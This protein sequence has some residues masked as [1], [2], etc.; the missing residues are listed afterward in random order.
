MKNKNKLWLAVLLTVL[1]VSLLAAGFTAAAEGRSEISHILVHRSSSYG[2]CTWLDMHS[3]L[4]E[5]GLYEDANLRQYE[6]ETANSNIE[7]H[8][9]IQDGEIV[10][11]WY[12]YEYGSDLQEEGLPSEIQDHIEDYLVTEPSG[13]H[14]YCP[15]LTKEQASTCCTPGY[16]QK[17][18]AV[19]EAIER[20]EKPLDPNNHP[21]CVT[22]E[23]ELPTATKPGHEAGVQ[24]L[25]CGQ[26]LSGG[27]VIAPLAEDWGYCG[28]EGDGTNLVWCIDKNGT[29]TISGEGNMG[30]YSHGTSGDE[31]NPNN[32]LRYFSTAPWCG[33]AENGDRIKAVVIGSGVTGIG[34]NAFCYCEHLT[35]VTIA[36]SVTRVGAGAFYGCTAYAD[37]T[38]PDGITQ[39]GSGVYFGTAWYNA[40]PDGMVYVGKAAYKYKGNMPA[41][42]SV[43]IADGTKVIADEAFLYFSNL[44]RVTFPDSLTHI[45]YMAFC[46]CN[47][48][49]EAAFPEGLTDIA[50]FAF[51]RC[52][53]LKSV[54]IPEGVMHVGWSAFGWCIDMTDVSIP[55][56]L[57]VLE[58][59]VFCRCG[60]LTSVTIP[61]GITNIGDYTFAFCSSLKNL[62]IPNSV[63]SIGDYAFYEC[64]AI[65]NVFFTGSEA[66]WNAITVGEMNDQLLNANI[67]YNAT[68]HTPG[69]AVRENEIPATCTE[70][71]SHDEVVYC[72]QCPCEVSRNHVTV[73]PTGHQNTVQKE[74]TPPREGFHEHGHEAGLYCKDC[75]TYLTGG[76]DIHNVD[77]DYIIIKEPTVD[78]TGEIKIECSKCGEWGLYELPKLDPSEVPDE[79]ENPD[80]P[81]QPSGDNG[82][83]EDNSIWGR[84]R[85]A[86][87]GFIETLLRL[88]RWLGG[89]K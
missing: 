38:L 88:I 56:S 8:I 81:D 89:K 45:G 77:G 58:K 79:P 16:I 42:T 22:V 78:E 4:V 70:A 55:A 60:S 80:Q 37:V 6:N 11:R 65:E 53:S 21:N 73:D 41:D 48:L 71:G 44:K 52:E 23:K 13:T 54:A 47:S 25:D 27:E 75:K 74:K 32:P 67:H 2:T 3:L 19:C 84:I 18:C 83:D 34:R 30:D 68:G 33:S 26:W 1:V 61:D 35:S 7:K 15:E 46:W 76:E 14:W 63:T 85:R 64:P 31:H 49:E 9:I 87:K 28:G 10:D 39:L 17:Q 62:T 29:L 69:E 51:D 40:Q 59:E 36:E 66:Q 24:C 5:N 86:A 43:T 50:D 12:M 82:G 57:T 20:T 72:T